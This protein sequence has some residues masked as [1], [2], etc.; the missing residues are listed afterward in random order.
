MIPKKIHYC[1]FGRN[2]KPKLAEKCIKSWQKFCPDFEII[3]WN[4]DNFDVASAPDYVQQAYAHKK[5]AFVTDFVRLQAM[6]TQGGIYMDTDVELVKPLTPYLK[7]EAFGG[8]E[9]P[10][11]VC[12]AV[13]ACREGFPLFR[14]FMEHYYEMSF[15]NPDGSLNVTT[16]VDT[17]SEILLGHGL[18]PNGLLQTVAGLTIYPS[19]VFSP[20]DF[21]SGQ[22]HRTRKTV[23]IHWFSGSWYTE[24][25]KR[26][27][28]ELQRKARREK[29]TGP[30]M[31]AVK[32]A[33]GEEGWYR[34]QERLERYSSWDQ[35]KRMPRRIVRKLLG[36]NNA[37]E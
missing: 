16:N 20:V 26:R 24:E 21:E 31:G 4:E 7:H 3:E 11:R 28:E 12:T 30:V 36:K 9:A 10:D 5:W 34:W 8:F 14:E 27:R 2:P 18:V 25:E 1:W 6:T 15:L 37:E 35:V 17:V 23:G 32:N 19:D 22:L 33:L 13:M 29:I